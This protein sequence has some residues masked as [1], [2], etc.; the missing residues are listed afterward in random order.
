MKPLLTFALLGLLSS[1]GFSQEA[2][3]PEVPAEK[4]EKPAP[5]KD[6]TVVM[7]TSMGEIHIEM[8]S[9]NSPITVKNFLSYVDAK[10]YDNTIFHR[11]LSTFMIQGGGFELK[12]GVQIRKATK[13]PIKNESEKSLPNKRGTLAMA[14]T[15]D[16]NSATDQFFI[17]VVDNPNLNHGGPYGGYATFAK[18]VKGMEVVDQIK[19]VET[20][21][22]GREKAKPV[23]PVIIK[24]IRRLAND[25]K[26]AP[27]EKPSEEPAPAATSEKQ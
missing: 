16:L 6:V 15:Q 20:T 26:E 21:W 19:D 9:K 4:V 18:V 14:R 25:T 1:T 13:A 10:H 2:T 24:S 5:V 3:K 8:D 11:V 23:E 7:S 17:N 22:L 12:D 27:T